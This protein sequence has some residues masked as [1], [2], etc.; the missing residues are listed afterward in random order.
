L[1]CTIDPGEMA[2]QLTFA[3][4]EHLAQRTTIGRSATC[5]F[6]HR[7][8]PAHR[9]AADPACLTLGGLQALAARDGD[10]TT[11]WLEVDGCTFARALVCDTC[12]STRSGWRLVRPAAGA[13]LRCA[14]GGALLATAFDSVSRL[15][16]SR[17]APSDTAQPLDGLGLSR[18]DVIVLGSARASR[19]IEIGAAPV[20]TRHTG[21]MP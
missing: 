20:I 5:R 21:P 2:V 1:D 15:E 13:G 7:P 3:L 12:G 14:C 9:F 10:T 6:D 4:R 16:S 17:L 11:W 18:G 19:A 8:L